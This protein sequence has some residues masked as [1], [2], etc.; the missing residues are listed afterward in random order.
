MTMHESFFSIAFCLI[1]WTWIHFQCIQTHTS[2]P[3]IFQKMHI[4]FFSSSSVSG[5]A[6]LNTTCETT[7][8]LPED[9]DEQ[10]EVIEVQILPQVRYIHWHTQQWLTCISQ[11]ENW[12]ETTTAVTNVSELDYAMEDLSKWQIDN[13]RSFQFRWL[14]NIFIKPQPIIIL[15]SS[16]AALL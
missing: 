7:V 2:S 5:A 4:S 3:H 6:R 16:L 11:D 10:Q 12:G 9:S 14:H 15:I 1:W 13:Q 8:S